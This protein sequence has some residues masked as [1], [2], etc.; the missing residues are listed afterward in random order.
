MCLK[1]T[2]E[3]DKWLRLNLLPLLCADM[4]VVPNFTRK[5][6]HLSFELEKLSKK[7]AEKQKRENTQLTKFINQF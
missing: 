3:A 7:S 5:T 4:A 1:T 6:E 2:P